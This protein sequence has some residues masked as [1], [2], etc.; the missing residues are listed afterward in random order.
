MSTYFNLNPALLTYFCI[1]VHLKCVI[2]FEIHFVTSSSCKANDDVITSHQVWQMELD[3]LWVWLTSVCSSL[4]CYFFIR[5]AAKMRIQRLAYAL[6]LALTTPTMFI[7]LSVMC[8]IWNDGDCS[9]TSS[10]KAGYLFFR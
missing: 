3:W 1:D 4:V 6:P 5:S 7:A 8:S 2:T 10:S 9:Y